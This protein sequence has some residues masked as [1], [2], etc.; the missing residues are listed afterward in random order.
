[1]LIY[2]KDLTEYITKLLIQVPKVTYFIH[3]CRADFIQSRTWFPFGWREK[4]FIRSEG[5]TAWHPGN[6][7]NEPGKVPIRERIWEYC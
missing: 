4:K 5:R 6:F 2:S 7:K 3:L 1:M